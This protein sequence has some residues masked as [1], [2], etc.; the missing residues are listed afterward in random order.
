M[1]FTYDLTATGD[2]LLIAKV[3]LEIGDTVSG[4][5]VRP[6]NENLLD[7]EIQIWLDEES[8]K[9][10]LAAARACFALARMWS[11]VASIS[12]GPHSEQLGKI[13]ES[14]QA[15][16]EQIAKEYGPL[17]T[18]GALTVSQMGRSDGYHQYN[19]WSNLR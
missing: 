12:E 5:G 4:N 16:G 18:T 11:N 17:S 14:W 1:A 15:R 9:V 7:E 13:S 19:S 2:T 6:S 10:L 3:R 8:D